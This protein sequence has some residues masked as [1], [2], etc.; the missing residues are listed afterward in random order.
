MPGRHKGKCKPGCAG[1]GLDCWCHAPRPRQRRG[2]RR[3]KEP[4]ADLKASVVKLRVAL[5]AVKTYVSTV[6]QEIEATAE[7]LQG[8]IGGSD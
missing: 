4:A 2:P 8:M 5:E 1:C 3:I 6:A 7:E